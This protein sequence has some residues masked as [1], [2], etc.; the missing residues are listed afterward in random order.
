MATADVT[1]MGAGIFG[2]AAAVACG[3]GGA[4]VRVIDPGGVA[5]G[6][7]GGI[8][9]ALAPHAPDEDRWDALKT[10]Q[11]D[12]LL[13]AEEY[14][15]DIARLSGRDPGYA[16][17]GRL[18]PVE[19]EAALARAEGRTDA[20]ASLWQGRA[21]WRV[22]P[23][24]GGGWGPEGGMVIHDTLSARIAPRA[25]CAALRAAL[26][27]LGGEV[28][29]EGHPEGAVIWATGA[30]GLEELNALAG[31]E[32]GRGIKGQAALLQH[33][34][35]ALPQ[36]SAPGLHVVPHGDGTVAI[37]STSEREWEVEGPDDQLNA[38][39]ARA[40]ALVP[41]LA[42]APV[43]E[44]WAGI[45][46]RA[47]TRAPMLGPHP[48]RQNAWIANGGFKIGL[49]LAPLAG[50]LLADLVLSGENRIPEEFDP[51]ASLTA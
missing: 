24:P 34:A 41:A 11:L 27:A 23:A 21:E 13:M 39:I 15:A 18:Q 7:S 35:A 43:I 20:A 46:P 19:G 22:I 44:R 1:V 50:E 32:V 3:R 38:V 29:P 40:R 4:H 12:A 2:L 36:L 17:T 28:V 31:R 14:W 33:D 25:A 49:A 8:V 6:A 37:G 45:R 48:F 9:G 16:R 26:E 5:A 30:A 51:E 10:F 47:R 42:E